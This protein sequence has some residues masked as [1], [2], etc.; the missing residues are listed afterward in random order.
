MVERIGVTDFWGV[1]APRLSYWEYCDQKTQFKH[2]FRR[3]QGTYI[4]IEIVAKSVHESRMKEKTYHEKSQVFS[5]LACA[6]FD[7]VQGLP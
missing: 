4:I 6:H 1:A 7:F 2:F 3:H 5:H